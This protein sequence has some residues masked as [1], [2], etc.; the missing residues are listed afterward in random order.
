[1]GLDGVVDKPPETICT[2]C[3]ALSDVIVSILKV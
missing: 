2:S 1:M 3:G